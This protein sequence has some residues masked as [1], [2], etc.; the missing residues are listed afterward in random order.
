MKE[1]DYITL[2][3]LMSL[4]GFFVTISYAGFSLLPLGVAVIL[5]Y[6]W[7]KKR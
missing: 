5:G 1:K 6:L 3:L 4:L 2:A 7:Y